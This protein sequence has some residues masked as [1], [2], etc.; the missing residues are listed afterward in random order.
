MLRNEPGDERAR[1]NDRKALGAGV[2]EGPGREQ[3]ADA[4][5]AR[6][7]VDFGVHQIGD[8]GVPPVDEH[9]DTASVEGRD[10][11]VVLGVVTNLNWRCIG[12]HRAGGLLRLV[13]ALRPSA[14]RPGMRDGAEYGRGTRSAGELDRT[15]DPGLVG[16][17]HASIA[18]CEMVRPLNRSLPDKTERTVTR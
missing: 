12:F 5:T 10:V 7:L 6:F 8:T 2:V 17:A 15:C 3:V 11:A 14:E 9:P 4:V 18:V 13:L 16:R 1:R